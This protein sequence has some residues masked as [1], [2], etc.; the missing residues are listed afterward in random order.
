MAPWRRAISLIG[1][2]VLA[3]T[4]GALFAGLLSTSLAVLVERVD[5]YLSGLLSLFGA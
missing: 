3:L 4:F 5:Y 1:R 2:G